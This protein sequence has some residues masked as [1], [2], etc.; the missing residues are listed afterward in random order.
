MDFR[1]PHSGQSSQLVSDANDRSAEFLVTVAKIVV[2]V[3]H[4][5]VAFRSLR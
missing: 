1:F 4:D 3:S 5:R 2:F